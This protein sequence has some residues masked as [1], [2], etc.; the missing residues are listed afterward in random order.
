MIVMLFLVGAFMVV[1]VDA[2]QKLCLT[3]G[4]SVP[5]DENPRYTCW[6]DLCQICVTDN[7]YPAAPYRCSGSCGTLGT[8][9]G[10]DKEGPNLTVNSPVDGEVYNSRRVPFDITS[11]EPVSLYYLDNVNGRGRW[12]RMYSRTTSYLRSLSFK[13]GMNNITIKG[14]DKNGNAVEVIRVFYV[15]SK[16]PRVGSTEPRRGFA[17]GWFEVEI[18]EENLVGVKLFYGNDFVGVREADLDVGECDYNRGKYTCDVDVD[19]GDYDGQ[20]IKYWFE[21][22]DIAGQKDEGREVELDVDTTLPVLNN[23][24]FWAQGSGRYAK[25][26]YFNLEIDEDN[27][28][29]VSYMDLNDRR[30]RWSRLCSRLKN[31]ICETKKSFRKGSHVVDIQIVDEAGNMISERIEFDV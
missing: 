31:G 28:E 3:Y 29:E 26:I 27:F 4:Q 30:P 1:G 14:T 17:D 16:E 2:Y 6:H 25:Y 18:S 9:G 11:N 12:R 7:L 23:A 20:T 22:E 5:S 8:S 24:D 10:V 15:D 21:A 19:L 13:E